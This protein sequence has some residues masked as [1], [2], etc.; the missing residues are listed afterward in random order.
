MSFQAIRGGASGTT[1][2]E[3]GSEDPW[4]ITFRPAKP[5]LDAVIEMLEPLRWLDQRR[6]SRRPFFEPERAAELIDLIPSGNRIA[7]GGALFLEA[8]EI[9]APEGWMHVAVGLMLQSQANSTAIDGDAYRCAIADGAFRDPEVWGQYDPG[10]SAAVIVR[11][12]RQARRQG[13]LPSPGG[14]S[15]CAPSKG[16]S[17]RPGTPM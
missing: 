3:P 12:I 2:N 4:E 9:S 6:R 8:E 5:V 10:F 13:A 1:I 17:S 14:S 7:K 11:T 16:R 15:T